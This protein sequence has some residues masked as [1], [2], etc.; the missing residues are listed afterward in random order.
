VA[1]ATTEAAK[2]L[3]KD[4]GRQTALT[5]MG[6]MRFLG[7]L[8][9]RD[10]DNELIDFPEK[11]PDF[12]IIGGE[13]AAK[14]NLAGDFV[15]NLAALRYCVTDG[16]VVRKQL[17][18]TDHTHAFS[19]IQKKQKALLVHLNDP[20]NADFAEGFLSAAGIAQYFGRHPDK[21]I[22][23][24]KR[25]YKL[26]YNDIDN[27]LL[28]CHGCNLRKSAKD[29]LKWFGE[30]EPFLGRDFVKAVEKVGGFFDGII[31][32]KVMEKGADAHLVKIGDIDCTLH[33]GDKKVFGMGEFV[34]KWFEETNPGYRE[35]I[36]K[37]YGN[38][39]LSLK[40]IFETRLS[41]EG[42]AAGQ[43]KRE[44]GKLALVLEQSIKA[45][46]DYYEI[47]KKVASSTASSPKSSS[48][49]SSSDDEF[50]RK[51]RLEIVDKQVKIV[52][53]QMHDIKKFYKSIAGSG[54]PVEISKQVVFNLLL[55]DDHGLYSLEHGK[56]QAALNE[57]REQIIKLD[58][59]TKLDE[60]VVK[61]IIEAAIHHHSTAFLIEAREAER[62]RAEEAERGKAEAE[63]KLAAQGELIAR[64]LAAQSASHDGQMTGSD[65]PVAPGT[66][67][68]A[69]V[70]PQF[71]AARADTLHDGSPG[72]SE[73]ERRD[74][75]RGAPEAEE[76]NPEQEDTSDNE[77]DSHKKSKTGSPPKG[78]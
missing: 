21:S 43:T 51:S 34:K 71:N 8:V 36:I 1:D 35:D 48:Q 3:K 72:T 11:R 69:V 52:F 18:D 49:S 40:A 78:I 28:L 14:S 63:N 32:K 31:I 61:P 66:M 73:Q 6:E 65:T 42:E 23:G 46:D 62:Q 7:K 39:W 53:E 33:V 75:K 68:H 19:D 24:T 67:P 2:Q 41:R 27:L 54:R 29:S 57:I 5:L 58:A 30:Q 9:N 12:Q 55:D 59:S 25:F 47:T 37:A 77:S 15:A 22:K 70:Q 45:I 26:C 74:R 13:D 50:D 56:Q 64:L 16:E 60:S 44:S 10:D 17:F 38:V 20:A 76:S 4:L